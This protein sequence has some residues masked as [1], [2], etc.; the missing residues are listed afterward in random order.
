M[1]NE[2]DQWTELKFLYVLYK[3]R[4]SENGGWGWSVNSVS[5][6]HTMSFNEVDSKM[7]ATLEQNIKFQPNS[8]NMDFFLFFSFIRVFKH[9]LH[10]LKNS[11]EVHKWIKL[12]WVFC[13]GYTHIPS[14][15]QIT[16]YSFFF[17]YFFFFYFIF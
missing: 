8:V 1:A 6:Q 11:D 4:V 12:G 16:S 15:N 7:T 3:C 9:P 14:F 2:I 10:C 5:P 17:S 13:I